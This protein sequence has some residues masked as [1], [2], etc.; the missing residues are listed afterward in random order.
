MLK[1]VSLDFAVDA[2]EGPIKGK[3]TQGGISTSEVITSAF[4]SGNADVFPQILSLHV[5]AGSKIADVTYGSG[6]FWRK[7]DLSQYEL[8][9]TDIADG[10]DCR[11]LP[12]EAESLDALV[13][14]PPYMEGLLR[15]NVDHKAGSGSHS[16]FRNYY[17]N[18]NEKDHSGPKWHAAVSDLYYK[19]GEE[20]AR[21]LKSKGVMIVKCQDEVSANRQWLTHVEIINYYEKLGFYCKDLFVVVRQNKAVVA[22]LLKQAHARKNHSYFLVFIKM[23][24]GKKLS[25]MRT[26]SA[27]DSTV[28]AR[29]CG[30]APRSRSATSSS[31]RTKMSVTNGD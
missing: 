12:Y 26:P 9:P 4:V 28:S 8:L 10:I 2:V 23:P 29:G 20:G 21:V 24:K 11:A 5:P 3:R 22:R 6:V 16:A 18:G 17:S 13:L 19:A 31:R 14:D 15:N 1:Q 25:Q 30:T 27:Q 7:V